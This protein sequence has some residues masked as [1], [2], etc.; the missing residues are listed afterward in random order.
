MVIVLVERWWWWLML[1][2]NISYKKCHLQINL[3]IKWYLN[4]WTRCWVVIFKGLFYPYRQSLHITRPKFL[5]IIQII[6]T[7]WVFSDQNL[8]A[9]LYSL[10]SEGRRIWIVITS[11][12]LVLSLHRP[13]FLRQSHMQLVIVIP[14]QYGCLYCIYY[15]IPFSLLD[16]HPQNHPWSDGI[17]LRSLYSI[18]N[19]EEYQRATIA[20]E[21]R[22]GLETVPSSIQLSYTIRTTSYW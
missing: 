17:H 1:Q 22:S 13:M 15:T 16:V 11:H 12:V 9:P 21:T 14:I 3:N 8:S 10:N 19:Q 20:M 2:N 18:A 7:M 4:C 6:Q 5:Q